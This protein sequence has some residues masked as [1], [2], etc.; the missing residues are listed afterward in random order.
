MTEMR[1]PIFSDLSDPR[2][3]ADGSAVFLS[4][5]TKD[6][7]SQDIAILTAQLPKLIND[8]R[9]LGGLADAVRRKLPTNSREQELVLPY[10]VSGIAVTTATT[11]EVVLKLATKQGIPMLLALDRSLAAEAGAKLTAAATQASAKVP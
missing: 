9:T 6:G 5:K 11:G 10:A 4:L 1:F 7:S 8:L 2:T 3:N